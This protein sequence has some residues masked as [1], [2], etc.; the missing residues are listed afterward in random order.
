MF[1]VI[2]NSFG[3]SPNVT[4]PPICFATR[5]C[6]TLYGLVTHFNRSSS[7]SCNSWGQMRSAG[8]SFGCLMASVGVP[9]FSGKEEPQIDAGTKT[10]GS[11]FGAAEKNRECMQ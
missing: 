9:G 7:T 3:V 10:R 6:A 1:S 11:V 8:I 2:V 5:L 4:F